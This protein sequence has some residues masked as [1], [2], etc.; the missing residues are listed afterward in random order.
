MKKWNRSKTTRRAK[1][2]LSSYLQKYNRTLKCKATLTF[3]WWEKKDASAIS[4]K[5]TVANTIEDVGE[6]CH[7]RCETNRKQ[8]GGANEKLIEKGWMTFLLI[9]SRN[10]SV[11]D[12]FL[13]CDSVLVHT[14]TRTDRLPFNISHGLDCKKWYEIGISV[15]C[16]GR[17]VSLEKGKQ[18]Q[19]T[20]PQMQHVVQRRVQL[21]HSL[22]RE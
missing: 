5:R 6:N 13:C 3:V 9:L 8:I 2:H 19:G 16:D 21:S 7:C 17:P 18:L 14:V 12:F 10:F 4:T 15:P 22:C 20:T 1:I 11:P